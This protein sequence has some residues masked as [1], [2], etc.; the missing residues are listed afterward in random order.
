[1]DAVISMRPCGGIGEAKPI[2]L[3]QMYTIN[4]FFINT[5]QANVADKITQLVLLYGCYKKLNKKAE[6]LDEFVF[7]GDILLGD[8]ND[9]D[10]YLVDP[11]QLFQN[12]SDLKKI[13]DDFS[14]L[15]PNQR[16]AIESF[17][18]HFKEGTAKHTSL[19]SKGI[20]VKEEFVQ[21]WNIMYKLYVDFN[22]V[23]ERKSLAYEGKVYSEFVERIKEHSVVDI[24]NSRYPNVESFCFVG[25]N[26][27]NEC[28]KYVLKSMQQA[29]L[30]EFCWDY[31]SDM[32]KDEHNKSS[33]F[34]S[35]NVIDFPQ[36]IDFDVDGLPETT[37]NV[38][39]VPS[40]YGQT[41]HVNQIIQSLTKSG[42]ELGLSTA[43][44][45]PDEVLLIP[46]LNSIHP[47]IESINVTM[48]YPMP[49]SEIYV[50]MTQ[51]ND[52][53]LHIRRK[54]GKTYFYHKQVWN[55]FSNGLFNRLLEGND[56]AK[57]LINTIKKS[58]KHYVDKDELRLETE[59][60]FEL[61]FTPVIEDMSLVNKD[62][63]L[64]LAKY[65]QAILSYVA[66]KIVDNVAMLH[67]IDFAKEY[68]SSINRLKAMDLEI[69]PST[70]FKLL[71]S[72]LSTISVPFNGEPLNGLQVMGPLETRAL[73]FKNV[74]ILSMNEG[75]F[76]KR[77]VSSS[78]IPPELRRG[79]S[80]PTYEFQ[81][82]VWAYY[83]YRLISR[84][85]NV[86]MIYDSRTEG[87]QSGEESRYIKQLR[88]HFGVKI[89]SY[90]SDTRTQVLEFKDE[91][92][93]KTPEILK[94]IKE[95]TYS[96]SA[97]Q[98]YINCP[99]SF[100]YSS[101][102]KL[103]KED[104]VVESMDASMI[105][106]VYHSTMQALYFS[107][108][109]M[110]PD[111]DLDE[112]IKVNKGMSVVSLEYLKKWRKQTK[113]IKQRVGSFIT[114]E[115]KTDEII[116]RNL[117][118]QNV[119]VKY[120]ERTIGADIKLLEDLK[121]DHFTIKGLE[122][123]VNVELYG[124]NFFGII[125]RID[126]VGKNGNLRLSDYKSGKDNPEVLNVGSGEDDVKKVV[127]EIFSNK[128]KVRREKKAGLQF[129]IYNKMIAKKYNIKVT[130]L[131][132]SMYS[133]SALFKEDLIICPVNQ[134]FTDLI[135]EKLGLCLN[136]LQNPEI[137][138]RRTE[139]IENCKWC[140]FKM[141]CGR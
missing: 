82:A 83:F 25:L 66:S 44:V 61:I 126:V 99:M 46:L 106:N 11:E 17:I 122:E 108:E 6:S 36:S 41:K 18:K 74:I 14:Y 86:W 107:D 136:D 100:Y 121:E 140:D 138:F 89:N 35:Q 8:F 104:E 81:D 71:S 129:F 117:I 64:K 111:V 95:L 91:V 79:F 22:E 13:E 49:E 105:G 134:V 39:S 59:T 3:P 109:A 135:D 62:Q 26:A 141:I 56:K 139:D 54:E 132:N 120:V 98:N 10:K 31:T 65:Q 12:I 137:P 33:F 19:D 32:I 112:Y 60:L 84:A 7:W 103:R 123:K 58:A 102:E 118:V 114:K 101:I 45:L 110:D 20:N 28:E 29:G 53:Q 27:L 52:L 68:Y 21:I 38:L 15:T 133:A 116:G 115:L 67:E 131:V 119:I 78:F 77:N 73:D 42:E 90:V 128:S 23:L 92:V 9:V 94:K 88:Y 63:I 37:F 30:A 70:Y 96:A 16:K 75:V 130:S 50:F 93:V 85:E 40:S 48:G 5:I 1:M 124:L 55:L 43:V 4:D 127:E 76:P 113:A 125:D 34:M 80:L 69:L 72:I 87:L 51:I 97:I 47:S 2:L 24:L 57:E